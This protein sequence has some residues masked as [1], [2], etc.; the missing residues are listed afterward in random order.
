MNSPKLHLASAS[1]RRRQLLDGLGLRFSY[2]GTHIDESRNAGEPAADLVLRL[3]L[4]K[5]QSA[6]RPNEAVL[7][8]DTE[9][10]LGDRIFGKPTSKEDA[11][12][13]LA[14]LSGQT[15]EVLTGIALL[16]CGSVQQRL[17]RNRVRFREISRAEAAAYWQT[18]EPVD[19]A[20]GYAI[21]GLAAVFVEEL[22]GSHSGV[23]G[24]P[25]FETAA[26]LRTIGI[27]VLAGRQD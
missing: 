9:V 12:G 22:Q 16:H 10:V 5:A 23:I 1:P 25:V 7:G 2:A 20:G 18:G 11:E 6:D 24:L 8:F 15:H 3:A 19:K 13:M 14:A 27:D 26:L 17:C 4:Q 21:Q